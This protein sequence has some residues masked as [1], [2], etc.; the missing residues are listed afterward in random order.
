MSDETVDAPLG[1]Y[2]AGDPLW[3]VVDK[4]GRHLSH[5]RTS[6]GAEGIK[7][8]TPEAVDFYEDTLYH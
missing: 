5:H 8:N 6:H 2:D 7:R 1:R 4:E 3:V